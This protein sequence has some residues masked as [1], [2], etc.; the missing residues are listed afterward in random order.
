MS[1]P[2]KVFAV[3]FSGIILGG[4]ATTYYLYQSVF[5]QW[6]AN[7]HQSAISEA[8]LIVLTLEKIRANK[9]SDAT[10]SLEFDLDEVLLDI[11]RL[12]QADD[13]NHLTRGGNYEHNMPHVRAYRLAYPSA[14]KDEEMLEVISQV[15]NNDV[16]PAP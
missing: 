4:T 13:K 10:L 12:E 14:H 9:I 11:G 16:L 3:L 2:L 15:I 6:V 5:V 7:E 1:S 8:R